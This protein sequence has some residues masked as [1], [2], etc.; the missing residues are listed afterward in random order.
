MK[1]RNFL[2]ILPAAGIT[3]FAVNGHAMRPF[4]NSKIASILNSCDGVEDRALVLIQLKGGNDGVNTIIP[5]N[6]YDT[7]ANL[8]PAIALPQ[9]SLLNLDGTLGNNEQVGLHPSLAKVKELYENGAAAIVQGVGYESLNQSHF[10]GTDLWFS[11]GDGTV[12]NSNIR[13]GWMGRA[14]QGF[15]PDVVGVPTTNMPDPLGIQIGNPNP[16][17]GFHTETEHQNVLN[18]SGQD[19]AG[20]YSLIQTI[21]GA[22]IT[23]VPDSEQGHELEYIMGVEQSTSQYAERITAVFNAGSN[24]L[25]TY[26]T[27][28]TNKDILANQLRTIARL[29]KGGCKTKIYLCQ[30]GGFDTH[31]S[32]VDGGSPTVGD[33]ADLLLHL[34]EAVKFFQEDLEGLGLADQVLTCTFSEF[35]RCA[36]GNGSDGTDHGTLAPMMLFGK[37]VNAGVLGTNVN[38]SDLT[39]DNQLKNMQFDYR[40]VFTTILQDWLGASEDILT[41]VMFEGYQKISLVDTAAVVDPS[42]YFSGSVGTWDNTLTQKPLSI[43]PN[44]T[45]GYTEVHFENA[46]SSFDARLSLHSLGGSLISNTIVFVNQGSNGFPLDV[47]NLPAG[48]Y[49]VRLENKQT[50]RA[51]VAKLNVLR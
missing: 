1:R 8:R 29:I 22:P 27:T 17:L 5:I 28:I 42:C 25:T 51:E 4:A 11:G 18:L 49:F 23:N 47:S 3:S 37:N 32:Q 9:S 36:K 43:F 21:G 38:L 6:Q 48:P 14:L 10:K 26:P 16:T 24:Y 45:R 31:S 40:Q 30:L 12:A 19:A 7:Y 41:Q 44:P 20:F 50:G 34:S 35:G 39:N 13:S 2:K 46:A 15:Y 33:H